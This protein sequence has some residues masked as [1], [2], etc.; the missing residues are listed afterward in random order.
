MKAAYL[1]RDENKNLYVAQG[2]EFEKGPLLYSPESFNPYWNITFQLVPI[3]NDSALE[4]LAEQLKQDFIKFAT[5]TI[6]IN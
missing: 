5:N 2:F 1:N 6:D 3:E 4:I